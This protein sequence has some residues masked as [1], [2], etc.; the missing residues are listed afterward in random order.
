M[1]YRRFILTLNN[2]KNSTNQ[3]LDELIKS[4]KEK[5]HKEIRFFAGQ[6]EKGEEK[7]TPHWQI[8][9]QTKKKIRK[10]AV[11]KLFPQNPHVER[12]FGNHEE[13][14]IY[15]TKEEGRIKGPWIVGEPKTERQRTDLNT[16]KKEI[17]E[18]K[19]KSMKDI[20]ENHTSI[21][22]NHP[23]SAKAALE[24]NQP[25]R[26][27]EMNIII[28][29]GESGCGKS[30][31]ASQIAPNAYYVM[32]PAKKGTKVWWDKYQHEETVIIDE[33]R[34]QFN[35]DF[36]LKLL[37]RYPLKVE[38]KGGI[39]EFNSKNLIITTNLSPL[40]WYPDQ[41][42]REP[43]LRRLNSKKCEIWLFEPTKKLK[44]IKKN[45]KF[46]PNPKFI[47]H[48]RSLKWDTMPI[49][50]VEEEGEDL[51]PEEDYEDESDSDIVDIIF[52]Q[53]PSPKIPDLEEIPDNQLGL[54][55]SH[56]PLDEFSEFKKF[57][58]E[59]KEYEKGKNVFTPLEDKYPHYPK[60]IKK[61]KRQ[62]NT[63]TQIKK[64]KKRRKEKTVK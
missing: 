27:W 16:F 38:Y 21:F 48:K 20:W 56:I 52:P 62:P 5:K 2:P 40:S 63:L 45:N 46:I 1:S 28:M 7:G 36:M 49:E 33:F 41:S 30:F 60:P 57:Q 55:D 37:D 44:W 24:I 14:L 51:T 32:N 15:C 12:C 4:V 50:E 13:C 17:K 61:R 26:N 34:E 19:I 11:K 9:I 10:T 39:T 43:L 8:Y 53:S 64:K 29:Y 58:K 31:K 22:I 42:D 3:F 25:K 18:G 59:L 47:I 23:N 6:I 35:Y 54:S